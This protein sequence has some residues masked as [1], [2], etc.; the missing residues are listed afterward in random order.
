[1]LPSPGAIAV[2]GHTGAMK[3][4]IFIMF[5][6]GVAYAWFS[7]YEPTPSGNSMQGVVQQF[8]SALHR[9]DIAGMRAVCGPDAVEDCQRLLDAIRDHQAQTGRGVETVGSIGFDFPRGRSRVD[10]Q[11]SASDVRGYTIVSA[12]VAVEQAAEGAPWR[13]VLIR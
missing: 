11:I 7:F 13:I 6:I 3:F 10:G 5:L 9:G 1:M 8:N 12:T 2:K 4:I